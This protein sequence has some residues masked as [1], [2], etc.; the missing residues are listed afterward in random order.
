MCGFA[1]PKTNKFEV[2]EV[3]ING[4]NDIQSYRTY[5]VKDK[6]HKNLL[7]V[8]RDNKYKL[9][10]TYTLTHIDLPNCADVSL[11][12]SGILNNDSDYSGYA[13][14]TGTDFEWKGL[15]M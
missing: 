15:Q 12:R 5:H 1:N 6:T 4:N 8:L 13:S 10:S 14:I 7:N 2:R 9:Y 3:T 11:A